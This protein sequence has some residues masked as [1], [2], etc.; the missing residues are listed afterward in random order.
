MSLTLPREMRTVFIDSAVSCGQTLG[1]L[2]VRAHRMQEN[3][4][5]EL[6][7]WLTVGAF[8]LGM[9]TRAWRFNSHGN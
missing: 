8:L 5:L 7:V 6:I 9:A 1:R 3:R 2:Q 4:P